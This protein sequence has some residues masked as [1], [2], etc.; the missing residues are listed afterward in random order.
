MSDVPNAKY[1]PG[2]W[3]KF[4]FGEGHGIGQIKGA[5]YDDTEERWIYT[6]SDPRDPKNTVLIPDEDVIGPTGS[7]GT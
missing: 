3:L 1:Q 5:L 4:Q 2:Q 7:V 6:V